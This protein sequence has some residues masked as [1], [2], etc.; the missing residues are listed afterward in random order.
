MLS[1]AS[2]RLMS[3]QIDYLEQNRV[4]WSDLRIANLDLAKDM[5]INA[6]PDGLAD[7]AEVRDEYGHTQFHFPRVVRR[8]SRS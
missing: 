3:F 6:V 4:A 1:T 7:R 2:E 5:A 8:A